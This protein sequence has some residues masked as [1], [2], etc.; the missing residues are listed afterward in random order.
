[1]Q[2]SSY[3]TKIGASYHLKLI[4]SLSIFQNMH[5]VALI[6]LKGRLTKMVIKTATCDAS[7]LVIEIISFFRFESVSSG[8]C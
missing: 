4:L 1:M 5:Q 3:I 6:K 7:N 2:I 8:G